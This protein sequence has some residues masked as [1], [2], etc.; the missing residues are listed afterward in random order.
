MN[1]DLSTIAMSLYNALV[2]GECDLEDAAAR[3]AVHGYQL[4]IDVLKDAADALLELKR[5]TEVSDGVYRV[6]GPPGM[7]VTSRNRD[8]AWHGWK[9]QQQN[10]QSFTLDSYLQNG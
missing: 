5:I 6:N 4:P 9:L 7:V 3:L 10:P 2:A 1:L 8:D